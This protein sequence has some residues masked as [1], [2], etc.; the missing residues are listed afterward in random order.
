[1]GGISQHGYPELLS[2]KPADKPL[3]R[4]GD[5]LLG[6]QLLGDQ[7]L[8]DQLLG[9]QLFRAGW[10]TSCC[11]LHRIGPADEAHE[12]SRGSPGPAGRLRMQGRRSVPA[13]ERILA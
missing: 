5:Q 10:G 3:S 2:H 4:L 9:D 8:G 11:P 13:P 7:L 12:R 1:M 6:D